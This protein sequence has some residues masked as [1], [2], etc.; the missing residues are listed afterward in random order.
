MGKKNYQ[1]IGTKGQDPWIV[2][3]QDYYYL[4]ESA[5]NDRKIEVKRSNDLWNWD[6]AENKVIWIP[7]ESDHTQGI[8]APEMH[9]ING[10]WYVYFAACNGQNSQH[11][12]Y[13]IE[14][15]NEDPWSK[16]TEKGKVAPRGEDYWAI[17]LT[18]LEFE[19]N[20]YAIWSG[21]EKDQTG[22]FPQRLYIAKMKNP[23]TISGKRIMIS[24]PEYNWEKSVQPINEGP[25]IIRK[26]GDIFILYSAN[27]SWNRAYKMGL[28]KLIGNNPMKKDH[29]WKIPHP[30]LEEEESFWGPGHGCIVTDRN[31]KE[32][33]VCHIKSK[34]E[35]GWEDR[36]LAGVELS[37]LGW[38]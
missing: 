35:E 25:E 19:K 27:A 15:T 31:G 4:I 36:M 23:W 7:T 29:W 16:Y 2:K 5:D 24:E 20:L 6:K 11:R 14:S 21:W 38:W 13:V 26:N 34:A 12:M 3:H 1:I 22:D 10:R 30:F 8:W 37:S 28:I 32:V 9:L 33:V 17:D 18:V